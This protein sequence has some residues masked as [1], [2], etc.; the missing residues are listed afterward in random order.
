MADNGI[1]YKGFDMNIVKAMKSLCLNIDVIIPN[2]T[3]AC[4]L[5]DLFMNAK[6]NI[7][8][9]ILW[10]KIKKFWHKNNFFYRN[11]IWWKYNWVVVGEKREIKYYKH[12]KISKMFHGTGDIYSSIFVGV[13][14]SGKNAFDAAKAAADFSWNVLIIL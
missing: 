4:F 8:K 13:Y 9:N 12:H 11:W 7:M 3:E 5:T 10:R 6:K 1:L 2:L 14:L